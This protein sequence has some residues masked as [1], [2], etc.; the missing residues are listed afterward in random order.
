MILFNDDVIVEIEKEVFVGSLLFK[1]IFNEKNKVGIEID[2][3]KILEKL[4]FFF[5]NCE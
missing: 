2:K 5:N 3:E 1:D 4:C